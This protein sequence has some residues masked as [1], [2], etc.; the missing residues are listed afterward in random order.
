MLHQSEWSSL[1]D[2]QLTLRTGYFEGNKIALW[3][4]SATNAT[5]Y[6][7]FT[8]KNG[9]WQLT[10][11]AELESITFLNYDQVRFS[12]A[13]VLELLIRKKVVTRFEITDEPRG[14]H[15]LYRKVLRNELEW[16]PLGTVVGTESQEFRKAQAQAH[17]QARKPGT[18]PVAVRVSDAPTPPVEIPDFAKLSD[19]EPVKALLSG[20]LARYE[21]LIKADDPAALRLLFRVYTTA[22]KEGIYWNRALWLL[23]K[24]PQTWVMEEIRKDFLSA[25]SITLPPNAEFGAGQSSELIQKP[26][27]ILAATLVR[28]GDLEMLT[29]LWWEFSSLSPEDQMVVAMAAYEMPR[30]GM[31]QTI[32]NATKSAKTDKIADA[33]INSANQLVVQALADPVKREGAIRVGEHLRSKGLARGFLL[34]MLK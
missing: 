19:S 6:W 30:L 28:I 17:P 14:D 21:A 15:S 33:L 26:K 22:K 34:E 8:Q 20:D 25:P 12:S 13:R 7:G 3:R 16:A 18:E 9:E 32:L 24:S 1:R 27:Y 10:D 2:P 31:V 5:E 11:M 29:R 23:S 4:V